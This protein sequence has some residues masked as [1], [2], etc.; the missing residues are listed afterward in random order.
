MDVTTKRIICINPETTLGHAYELMRENGIRHLPVVEGRRLV[1]LVSDRDL[2]L[3]ANRV[4]DDELSFPRLPASHIMS[5]ELVTAKSG[6]GISEAAALMLQGKVDS[7]PILSDDGAL[8]GFVTTSD[9][10]E[11]ATYAGEGQPLPFRFEL[12]M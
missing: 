8:A 5:T 7:L 12:R 9:F 10:L 4:S 2:L 6:V 11:L 1:G 3:Y